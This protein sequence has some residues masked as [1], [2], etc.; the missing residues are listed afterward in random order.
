MTDEENGKND[1]GI[2]QE[3]PLPSVLEMED[4]PIVVSTDES[5]TDETGTEGC[6]VKI[7]P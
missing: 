3:E 5:S 1:S 7:K 4:P 2:A 6:N